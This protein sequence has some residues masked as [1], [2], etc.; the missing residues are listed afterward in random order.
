MK[1]RCIDNRHLHMEGINATTRLTVGKFYDVI[2]ECNV[3]FIIINDKGE[4]ETFFSE[5]FEK[6]RDKNLNEL[7]I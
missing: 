7:G 3:G 6:L 2:E 1:V 5:R 4:K